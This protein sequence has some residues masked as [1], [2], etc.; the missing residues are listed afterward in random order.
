MIDRYFL[1]LSTNLKL[2]NLCL[3]N[4]GTVV[5]DMVLV[6]CQFERTKLHETQCTWRNFLLYLD[7]TLLTWIPPLE[8][9]RDF[10]PHYL[11]REGSHIYIKHWCKKSILIKFQIFKTQWDLLVLHPHQQ[12]LPIFHPHPHDLSH[13]CIHVLH[14]GPMLY[15]M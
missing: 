15:T 4:L 11:R 3:T 7:G 14:H 12:D 13:L 2:I 1:E 5:F 8:K 10:Y 6:I 9:R